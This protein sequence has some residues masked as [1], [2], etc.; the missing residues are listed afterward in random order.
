[1]R[2][3]LQFNDRVALGS[4]NRRLYRRAL[5]GE[6]KDFTGISAPY[7]PPAGAALCLD[8]SQLS[9]DDCLERVLRLLSLNT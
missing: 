9:M 3:P 6:L 8:T 5:A 2:L 4:C 1:M 7:E